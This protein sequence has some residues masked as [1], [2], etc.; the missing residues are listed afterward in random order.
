[1]QFH[2]DAMTCGHC[3]KNVTAA[4]HAV[5]PRARVAID[6]PAKRVTV[7]SDATDAAIAAALR[8]AGYPPRSGVSS[9]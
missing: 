5:D 3:A 2:I 1:M 8:D 9:Q 4:V 7:V 6:L